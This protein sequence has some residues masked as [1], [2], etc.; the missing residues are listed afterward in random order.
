[1]IDT[2]MIYSRIRRQ[3]EYRI[4][5]HSQLSKRRIRTYLSKSEVTGKA[6][7]IGNKWIEK[8]KY[9]ASVVVY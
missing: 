9:S 5:S 8:L 6:S 3:I 7:D 4:S 2:G 1:M